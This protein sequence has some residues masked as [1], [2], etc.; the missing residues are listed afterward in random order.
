MTCDV[1]GKPAQVLIMQPG[2]DTAEGPT[3]LCAYDLA[4]FAVDLLARE[5]TQP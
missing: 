2:D 4:R 5:T 3:P 1:C